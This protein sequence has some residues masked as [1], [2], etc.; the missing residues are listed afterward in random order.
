M[1]SYRIEDTYKLK[2]MGKLGLHD[3]VVDY[4]LIN[5]EVPV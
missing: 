3:S 5:Q 2:T 4:R 1:N